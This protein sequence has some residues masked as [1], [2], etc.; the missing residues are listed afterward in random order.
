LAREQKVCYANIA[1]ITDYD[2]GLAGEEGIEPVTHEGVM[3]VFN[4]NIERVKRVI[5]KMVHNMPAQ[6]TCDCGQALVGA[7]LG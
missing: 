5:T 2:V 7:R 1:L 4:A 3:Q 6:R